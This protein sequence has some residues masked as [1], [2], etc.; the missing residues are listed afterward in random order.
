MAYDNGYAKIVVQVRKQFR[1]ER[2]EKHLEAGGG[3]NEFIY[4][5]GALENTIDDLLVHLDAATKEIDRLTKQ[6]KKKFWQ[7]KK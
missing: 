1:D 4:A 5:H 6:P 3:L 2:L 7:R